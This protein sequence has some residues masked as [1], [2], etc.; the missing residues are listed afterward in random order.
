[1]PKIID[2]DLMRDDLLSKSFSLFA[3]RGFHAVTMR[4]LA[5]ELGVS[6]GTLYHYFS[7]KTDLYG[8]M[9]RA[10]VSKDVGNVLEGLGEA[11]SVQ[12][13]LRVV[14][15]YVTAHEEQ[16]KDLLLLLFDFSRY[17]RSV[18]ADSAEGEEVKK[19]RGLF[20]ELLGVYRDTI[21]QN[22]GI[23]IPGLGQ[24]I[25]SA[26]IGVLVQRIVEPTGESLK[27]AH[28]CLE[29]LIGTPAAEL[30]TAKELGS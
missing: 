8:Q 9:L 14:L 1:M 13:R 4:E 25:M 29:M 28:A 10:R 15:D 21:Q 2:H 26:L 18:P 16:F 7:G 17:S 23:S 5:R 20:S 30:R 24:M 27:E 19:I 11:M 12:A 22:A 6:T 3:R